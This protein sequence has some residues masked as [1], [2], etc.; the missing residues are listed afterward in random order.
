MREK[1]TEGLFQ[2]QTNLAKAIQAQGTMLAGSTQAGQSMSMLLDDAERTLGY[3]QAQIDASIF[4]A[5]KSFGI[6]QFGI[7][8]DQYSADVTASNNITTTASVAP[9]ASFMTTRPIKQAPPEKPSI[10]GPI[11]GGFSSGIKTA[12][13]L[14]WDPFAKTPTE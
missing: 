6:K 5:T 10:L 9:T 8:L 7:D 2:S 14:G 11:M 1:I 13:S 3:Q 4:D 12:T